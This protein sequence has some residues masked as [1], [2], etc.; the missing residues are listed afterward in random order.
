M[1]AS[2]YTHTHTHVYNPSSDGVNTTVLPLSPVKWWPIRFCI[3]IAVVVVM[4]IHCEERPKPPPPSRRRQQATRRNRRAEPGGGIAGVGSN[5]SQQNTIHSVPLPLLCSRL[6]Y[7]RETTTALTA[8][9]PPRRSVGQT[10]TEADRISSSNGLVYTTTTA[11]SECCFAPLTAA[12]LPW[13][14]AGSELLAL[15]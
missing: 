4:L 8:E 5:R 7:S 13:L 1:I 2:I 15:W 3:Y 12:M 11:T 10:E 14:T 9:Q 6:F